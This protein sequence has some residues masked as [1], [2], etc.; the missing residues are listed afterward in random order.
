MKMAATTNS[1]RSAF[2][3]LG[4]QRERD[5]D[6][7]RCEGIAEVVDE[8]GEQSEASAGDEDDGLGD[9]GDAQHGERQ[10]HRPDA[11]ARSLDAVVDQ[12]VRVAVT[13]VLMR[14]RL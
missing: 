9:R 2:G 11:L 5:T 4:A 7:D 1:P 3:H 8:V 10:Q 13:V 14:D 6:R 12:T